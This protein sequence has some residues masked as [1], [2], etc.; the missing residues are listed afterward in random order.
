MLRKVYFWILTG[1]YFG[2]SFIYHYPKVI[3]ASRK[4]KKDGDNLA[5]KYAKNF[6]K[7]LFNATGKRLD[8]I[9]KDEQD[10]NSIKNEPVVVVSN[11]QSNS[12]IILLLGYFPKEIGF[13]AKKEMETWPI[14]SFWMK[15][16]QC[17]FLDR[18]NPREGIKS[19]KEAAEKIKE[20]YSIVI[21]PEGT[22][23]K[24][25]KVG[26]FK[27]GSFKLASEPG[28]K[29]VPV[30]IKGNIS[31]FDKN[32]RAEMIIEKSID[33]KKLEK[34]EQKKLNEMVREIVIR[35]F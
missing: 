2:F 29:I 5:R 7:T 6:G 25:G 10:F 21:F 15:K 18:N 19:I 17:V 4:N 16:I 22:R 30:T 1:L 27:K 20:G 13:V 24:D 23:S 9:I 31:P 3:L 35:G 12:D 26:E 14:V 33:P 34:S 8:I 32:E 11:H 28:V